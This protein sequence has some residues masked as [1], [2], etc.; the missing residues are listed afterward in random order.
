MPEINKDYS[1]EEV[2]N[3]LTKMVEYFNKGK[4]RINYERGKNERIL[5]D[6]GITNEQALNMV[7][8]LT[9]TDFMH[10]MKDKS[11]DSKKKNYEADIFYVFGIENDRYTNQTFEIYIKWAYLEDYCEVISI[12]KSKYK[13]NFAFK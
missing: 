6:L 11:D 12:H 7:K 1:I 13:L 5:Q 8:E 10:T 3:F 9:V 4:L 2:Q